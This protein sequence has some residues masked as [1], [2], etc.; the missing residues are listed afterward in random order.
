MTILIPQNSLEYYEDALDLN[1]KKYLRATSIRVCLENIFD[2]V[3][4][5]ICGINEVGKVKKKWKNSTLNQKVDML[6]DYFPKDVF[7]RVKEITS[8]GNNGIHAK[9]NNLIT[10]EEIR[11]SLLDL[12]FICEWTITAYF[13]KYG[14]NV[15]PWLPTILS[16]L[17]PSNRIRILESTLSHTVELLSTSDKQALKSYQSI[18]TRKQNAVDNDD[19]LQIMEID[20]QFTISDNGDY[21]K[22]DQLHLLVDKLAMVYL[23]DGQYDRGVSFIKDCFTRDL[24]SNN[25]KNCML[26][27]L[28]DMQP[29]LKQF[30][31]SNSIN[32]TRNRFEELLAVVKEEEKSLFITVFTSIVAHKVS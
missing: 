18:L 17:P 4:L 16:T 23:K 21:Q 31:I 24:I 19:I 2:T 10:E 20:K 25:Y 26:T 13:H 14:F 15:H 27:K 29:N 5:H 7:E 28:E 30:N 12:S 8:I 32:E 3:F 6:R 11:L 1:Q 22:F 9:S